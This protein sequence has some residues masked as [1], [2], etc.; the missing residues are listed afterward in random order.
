MKGF[1]KLKSPYFPM[2]LAFIATKLLNEKVV[3]HCIVYEV[4][5]W[6]I[7]IKE[8]GE[9]WFYDTSDQDGIF[10]EYRLAK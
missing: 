6:Y 9:E 1:K 3:S 10:V 2:L 7:A 4:H 5:L 8:Y